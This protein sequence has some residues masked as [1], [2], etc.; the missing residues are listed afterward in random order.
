MGRVYKI[1]MLDIVILKDKM[2]NKLWKTI[3]EHISKKGLL[4]G[5]SFGTIRLFLY[6]ISRFYFRF[7]RSKKNMVLNTH[8]GRC[9]GLGQQMI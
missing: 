4:I 3:M 8:V 2:N 7:E 1:G 9:H 6:W 5:D